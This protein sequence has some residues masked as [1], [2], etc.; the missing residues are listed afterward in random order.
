MKRLLI[1]PTVLALTCCACGHEV[2]ENTKPD[3]PTPVEPVVETKGAKA[4]V[5]TADKSQLFAESTIE[6]G[7]A[8]SMSPNIV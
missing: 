8:A 4:Y 7:K 5:T 1:I 6:F 2:P 3:D